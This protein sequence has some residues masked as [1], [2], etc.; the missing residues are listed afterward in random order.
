TARRRPATGGNSGR[1]GKAGTRFTVNWLPAAEQEL[2][3]AWLHAPDRES[4]NKA[5]RAIDQLLEST[6]Q[7]SGESRRDGRRILFSP[8]LGVIYRVHA[9]SNLVEVV[10]VWRFRVP[11]SE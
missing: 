7:D 9:E 6:P 11:R 3:D 2:A 10:H 8:P 4:V 5:A 1:P